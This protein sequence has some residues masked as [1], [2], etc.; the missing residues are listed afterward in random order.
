MAVARLDKARIGYEDY[1]YR[2][3]A[4]SKATKLTTWSVKK[5]YDHVR[6]I[7]DPE[8]ARVDGGE[9]VIRVLA[10][11]L[12]ET[13]AGAPSHMQVAISVEAIDIMRQAWGVNS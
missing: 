7:L 1:V 2:P 10:A 5:L 11:L 8:F 13:I 12:G 3:K 9:R 6:V 4:G